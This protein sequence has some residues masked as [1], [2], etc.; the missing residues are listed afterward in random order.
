[1]IKITQAKIA[2]LYN[3]LNAEQLRESGIHALVDERSLKEEFVYKLGV[4]KPN[5]DSLAL[6]C[7]ITE[8]VIGS[9]ST[10]NCPA[11]A[12]YANMEG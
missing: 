4:D 11:Y 7:G 9:S 2:R 1:M 5:L 12:L 3:A 8:S 10:E 6:L